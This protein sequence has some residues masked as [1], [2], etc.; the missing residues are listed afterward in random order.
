MENLKSEIRELFEKIDSYFFNYIK[1]KK[2]MMYF[3]D[4]ERFNTDMLNCEL[5]EIPITNLKTEIEITLCNN[6]IDVDRIKNHTTK[7]YNETR[8]ELE[9]IIDEVKNNSTLPIP[10]V[11]ISTSHKYYLN[12]LK[13][14]LQTNNLKITDFYLGTL[15]FID[16]D[17]NSI[18]DTVTGKTAEQIFSD[19]LEKKVFIDPHELIIELKKQHYNFSKIEEITG[20]EIEEIKHDFQKFVYRKNA[21]TGEKVGFC[22]GRFWFEYVKEITNPISNIDGY[23]VPKNEFNTVGIETKETAQ[24]GRKIAQKGADVVSDE[25]KPQRVIDAEII[26]PLFKST[27]KGMGNN[28]MNYFDTFIDELK[29]DRTVK[30]FA[31]IAL[32][33]F[34]GKQM[35]DRKPSTWKKWLGMFYNCVGCVKVNYDNKNNLRKSTSNNLKK[36]FSYL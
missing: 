29:T 35:N 31:Q 5:F 7:V 1:I 15:I 23:F 18:M 30:E 2:S 22:N 26:K 17:F 24:K 8:Y 14:E 25:V 10:E 36:L 28:N 12:D 21:P 6:S 16:N 27:F 34:E 9:K 32:M 11:N 19:Y 33:C 4:N 20:L 13:T 3:I